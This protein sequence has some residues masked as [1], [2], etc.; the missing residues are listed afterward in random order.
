MACG[1]CGGARAVAQN[2]TLGYYVVLPGAGGLM[3]PGVNPENPTAGAAPYMGYYEARAQ[4]VLHGGGT[5]KRLLRNP[6]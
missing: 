4:V 2:N 1:S 5:I 3:P 6:V